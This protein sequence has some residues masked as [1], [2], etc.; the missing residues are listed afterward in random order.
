[1][2]ASTFRVEG[3]T[4]ASCVRR[5]EKALAAVPGVD[6][7]QVNLAT[8]EA[9][10][11]SAGGGRRG[12]GRGPGGPGL[13]PGGRTVAGPR[14]R[15]SVRRAGLRVG[16]AWVLTLPLM[17]GMLP[18]PAP[19]PALAG[20]GGRWR[21]WRP[22]GAGGGFFLRAGAPGPGPGRPAWT[23]SSPWAPR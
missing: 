6:A 5:V 4:C 20:P 1:M 16:A 13:P 10:V 21:P 19:A 23:R 2:A 7:A 22:S 8:E 12:P 15:T 14:T 11:E 18:G 3:M 17:A 9:A